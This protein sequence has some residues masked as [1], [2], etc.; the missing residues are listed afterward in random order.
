MCA[1][2]VVE[3]VKARGY[4][5]RPDGSLR[6]WYNGNG[7]TTTPWTSD[8]IIGTGFGEPGRVHTA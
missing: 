1:R 8:L 2:A 5:E 4:D 3:A 7:F 6:A